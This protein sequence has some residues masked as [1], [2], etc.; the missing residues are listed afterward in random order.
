MSDSKHRKF[1]GFTTNAWRRPENKGGGGA[2]EEI[3]RNGVPLPIEDKAVNI[4]VPE[5]TSELQNNGDGGSPFATEEYVDQN[6]GTITAIKRNGSLLPI[7]DKTVN[8]VVPVK[9]SELLNDNSFTTES[10]V[11]DS[12]SA[13]DK[14][15]VAEFGVTTYTEISEKRVDHICVVF[16][17]GKMYMLNQDAPSTGALGHI[18]YPFV[19]SD[20]VYCRED[21]RWSLGVGG[22]PWEACVTRPELTTELNNYA[23]IESPSFTGSPQTPTAEEG[24]N[25]TQIATTEFVQTAITNYYTKSETDA[26]VEGADKTFIFDTANTPTFNEFKAI[27]DGGEKTIIVKH[28]GK[29]YAPYSYTYNEYAEEPELPVEVTIYFTTGENSSRVIGYQ[30]AKSEKDLPLTQAVS[31]SRSVAAQMTSAYS[32]NGSV[33]ARFEQNAY[34]LDLN[35]YNEG[36]LR[37]TFYNQAGLSKSVDVSLFPEYEVCVN[38]VGGNVVQIGTIKEGSEQKNLYQFY[39]RTGELPASEGTAVYNFT[40]LL[41]NYTINGF[42]D[43]TGITSDGILIGNG[44]TD[45][46]NRL[47]VQQF[48]KNNK[49]ITIRVYRGFGSQ[50]ALLKIIFIGK[51]SS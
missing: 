20:F 29:F 26:L 47:I 21:N 41:A 46:N 45:N 23:K 44:R 15:F 24:T 7:V 17:S 50:T 6:V 4:D 11:D 33:S 12:V 39:Y 34:R 37:H 13:I 22:M 32:P 28:E 48:S 18:F 14:V 30:N 19:S 25:T 40:N 38:D 42:I 49:N 31:E 5:K 16:R 10:Y 3:Q 36:R 51:K 27:V 9:T 43:A 35:N 1:D 8:V 2:I